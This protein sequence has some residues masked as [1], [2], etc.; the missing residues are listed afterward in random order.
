[1]TVKLGAT[2]KDPGAYATDAVDGLLTTTAVVTLAGSV[3]SKVYTT[4]LSAYGVPYVITYNVTD[5]C[6]NVATTVARTVYIITPCVAP[7]TLCTGTSKFLCGDLHIA[8]R[9]LSGIIQQSASLCSCHVLVWQTA[10]VFRHYSSSFTAAFASIWP[11][12]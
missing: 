9:L 12:F 5:S 2:F 6:C 7:E 1:M 8:C 10:C 11:C 4:A 3:V